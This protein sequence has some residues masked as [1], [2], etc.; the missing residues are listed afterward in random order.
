MAKFI[1]RVTS[2]GGGPESG[3]AT[4]LFEGKKGRKKK[5]TRFLRPTERVMRRYLKAER[6]CWTDLTRR[7][8]KSR[9]KKNDRWLT[10]GLSNSLKSFDK[11]CRVFGKI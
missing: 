10:D 8:D 11:G 3:G 7:H 5:V 6:K 4:T 9:R 2:V 1:R